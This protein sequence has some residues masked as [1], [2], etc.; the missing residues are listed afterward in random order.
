MSAEASAFESCRRT[1]DHLQER[2]ATR[3][4]GIVQQDETTVHRTGQLLERVD[5]A[6]GGESG[7]DEVGPMVAAVADHHDEPVLTANVV[8]FEALGVDVETYRSTVESY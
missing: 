3:R 4:V 1:V 8:D 2:A 7:I 5:E 6:A